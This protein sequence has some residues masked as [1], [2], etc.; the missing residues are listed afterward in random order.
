MKKTILILV[1]AAMSVVSCNQP[2]QGPDASNPN[3]AKPEQTASPATKPDRIADE[4]PA[5]TRPA[6]KTAS[7]SPSTRAASMPAI[8]LPPPRL[9]ATVCGQKITSEKL[10]MAVAR[11]PRKLSDQEL[12]AETARFTGNMVQDKLNTMLADDAKIQCDQAKLDEV[13]KMIRQAAEKEK[14]SDEEFMAARDLNEQVIRDRIRIQKLLEQTTA[15]DKIDAFIKAH[16]DYFNGTKI[17]ASHILV[18]CNPTDDTAKQKAAL[19]KAEKI[20]KDI[21]DGKISFDDAAKQFSDDYSKERG[22]ELP[23]FVF[24]DMVPLFSKVAFTTKPGQ[25]SPVL[26]S[27]FGFHIIKVAAK[28]EGNETAPAQLQ[29]RIAGNALV[30]ELLGAM[31]EKTINAWTITIIEQNPQTQTSPAEK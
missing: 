10:D 5:A 14:L 13:H 24:A 25:V 17:Q 3:R 11:A 30:A 9:L 8:V 12:Q 7:T 31:M 6:E 20:A 27:E 16:P 29:Q 21:Q 23:E 19:A 2:Q 26:R 1:A 15:P 28:T 22:S 4:R 18:M